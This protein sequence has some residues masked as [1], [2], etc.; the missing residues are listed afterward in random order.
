MKRLRESLAQRRRIDQL[1]AQL[2]GRAVPPLMDSRAP[3]SPPR[4]AST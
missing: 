4:R 3:A 1:T 2:A